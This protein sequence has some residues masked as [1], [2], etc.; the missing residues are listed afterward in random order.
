[1]SASITPSKR[2]LGVPPIIGTRASVPTAVPR[3]RSSVRRTASSPFNDTLRAIAGGSPSDRESGPSLR[4]VKTS[5]A[6][7]PHAA[8]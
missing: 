4:V 7:A 1:V 5:E 3:L 8:L 2:G 6:L